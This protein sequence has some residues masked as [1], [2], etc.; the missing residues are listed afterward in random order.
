MNTPLFTL[1]RIFT[2]YHYEIIDKKQE[3]NRVN[4]KTQK[5]FLSPRVSPGRAYPE[6]TKITKVKSRLFTL[7]Q[8]ITT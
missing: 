7:H 6:R 4:S 5:N 2:L 3:V 8:L 1:H